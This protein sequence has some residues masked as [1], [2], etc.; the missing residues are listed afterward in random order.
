M[1]LLVTFIV[2]MLVA[3]PCL[4]AARYRACA[5]RRACIRIRSCFDAVG[6]QL[7]VNRLDVDSE[8]AC[9]FSLVISG[10][11]ERSEN[12]FALGIGDRGHPNRKN[13]LFG[14]QRK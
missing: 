12:Q 13:E 1:I 8:L 4:E 3:A 6:L 5:S 14:P 9:R 10:A 7:V 2:L 11:L